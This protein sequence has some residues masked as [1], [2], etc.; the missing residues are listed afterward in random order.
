[1]KP[2]PPKEVHPGAV[3]IVFARD[4]PQYDP[5]PAAV[6]SSGLVMTEWE[7]TAEDLARVLAGGRIRLWVWTFCRPLQPL[8]LEVV[9]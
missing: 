7:L 4:Q 5:L 2:I 9:E 1:M 6:D 3:P 8:A